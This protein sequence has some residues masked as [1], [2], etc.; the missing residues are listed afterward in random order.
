MSIHSYDVFALIN[1]IQD[2]LANAKEQA[3]LHK[4]DD[5]ATIALSATISTLEDVLQVTIELL[6]EYNDAEWN[7][8]RLPH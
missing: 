2:K 4:G 3:E 6:D 1:H 7:R 8:W 5:E